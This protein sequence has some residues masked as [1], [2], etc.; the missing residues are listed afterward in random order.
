MFDYK[1]DYNE[2]EDG[3]GYIM[4]RTKNEHRLP[5]HAF[6][7]DTEGMESI[8]VS[9][10]SHHMNDLQNK[11]FRAGSE[12]QLLPEP[13][14]PYDKNAIGVW[15]KKRRLQAGYIPKDEASRVANKL[16]NNEISKC[17]IMWEINKENQR[18]SIR[19]LLIGRNAS[20]FIP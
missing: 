5:W 10:E 12:V 8:P 13:D 2:Y 3:K 7:L 11:R 4:I 14:N 15:D 1:L 20:L 19:L 18:V 9:G 17:I 16:A 6:D